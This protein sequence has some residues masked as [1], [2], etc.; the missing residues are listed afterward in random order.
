MSTGNQPN[1]TDGQQAPPAF[2]PK[3]SNTGKWIMGGCGCLFVIILICGGASYWGYT[4]LFKPILDF[5]FESMSMAEDHPIVKEKI[6][7]DVT[8]GPP[9]TTND[10]QNLTL[11][12]PVSGENGNGTVVVSATVNDDITITKNE[13]YLEFKGEQ[14]DLSDDGLNLDIEDVE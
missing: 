3:E 6:G 5:T 8:A 4:S 7:D 9:A 11:R 14:F 1:F 13:A 12:I 10:G 2:Q